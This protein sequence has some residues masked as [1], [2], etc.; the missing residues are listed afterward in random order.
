LISWFFNLQDDA[1][2]AK[3][4]RMQNTICAAAMAGPSQAA[5]ND[6]SSRVP[7]PLDWTHLHAFVVPRFESQQECLLFDFIFLL[8]AKT[9]LPAYYY[10]SSNSSSAIDFPC[11]C[12]RY[13]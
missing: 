11:N 7:S 1:S 2:Y 6:R 8:I 13:T 10:Q 3:L 4:K 9:G 5:T 12:K